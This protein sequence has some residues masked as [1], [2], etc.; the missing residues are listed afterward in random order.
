MRSEVHGPTV[1]VDRRGGVLVT[2]STPSGGLG[3][4]MASEF[5]RRATDKPKDDGTVDVETIPKWL[6]R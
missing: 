2:V 4:S 5:R 1:L 6:R 3:W